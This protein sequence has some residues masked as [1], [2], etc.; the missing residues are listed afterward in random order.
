VFVDL[1]SKPMAPAE[2]RRFSDRLKPASLLDDRSR[3]YRDA[4]L[5]YMR[6]DDGE[7]YE[8]LLTDQRLL[9]LPLVRAGREVAVGADEK[10]WKVWL[11][12]EAT[13]Q[14]RP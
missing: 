7:L 3:A 12:T 8:R 6:L 5:G 9:R 14:S 1:D 13:P 10:T 2:L 11:A 4:G